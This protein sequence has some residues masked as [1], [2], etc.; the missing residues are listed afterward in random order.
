[1]GTTH[2]SVR[3]NASPASVYAALLDPQLIPRWRVPLGM[4]CAVHEFEAREGGVFRVS[5]TYDAPDATGKSS[6]HTDTYHGRF[7]QLVE[8]ERIV[9]CMEFETTDPQMQGEMRITTQLE[10]EGNGTRLTAVHE[11]LPPGVAPSDN[12]AGWNESLA[13]LAELL[14][15]DP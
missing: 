3:I 14:R 5:L 12:E 9:E 2:H 15:S 4:R 11:N 10:P 7:E 1:M 8:H 13:K 6:A